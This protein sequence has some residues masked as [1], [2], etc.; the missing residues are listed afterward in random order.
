MAIHEDTKKLVT[1]VPRS[2]PIIEGGERDYLVAELQRV[3]NSLKKMVEVV[4]LLEDR[5]NTNGLT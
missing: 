1:Y 4:K 3:S 2:Y 5:M